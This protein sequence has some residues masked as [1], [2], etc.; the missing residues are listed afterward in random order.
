MDVLFKYPGQ[1]ANSL[2]NIIDLCIGTLCYQYQ[3][4]FGVCNLVSYPNYTECCRCQSTTPR[5]LLAIRLLA[6]N[7]LSTQ[8]TV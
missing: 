8:S 7:D 5:Q 2:R 1:M 3:V 6:V 4:V